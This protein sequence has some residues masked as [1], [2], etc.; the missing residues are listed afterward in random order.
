MKRTISI[1]LLVLI[2]VGLLLPGVMAAN[3]KVV[4]TY[5][6]TTYNN[7]DYKNIVDNYFST[8]SNIHEAGVKVISADEV[9]KISTSISQK[10]YNSNQIFSSA[11]VDLRNGDDL[12]VDVDTS[13][14]TTINEDMYKSALKTAGIT[15]G[16]VVV[17][18]PVS[19]TGESALAGVMGCYEE[20]TG[21]EVPENVK[22]AAN[23]EIITEKEI[24]E[25]SNVTPETL[26]E[27]V[28]EV[29]EEA[30]EKNLTNPEQIVPIINNIV[31]NNNINLTPED[32]DKLANT[33]SDIVAA[34]DDAQDLE[35]EL[36]NK[37]NN[38]QSFIDKILGFFGL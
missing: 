36:S 26:S 11:L 34:Q 1:I 23:E 32:V 15:K 21:V 8:S 3:D 14:I 4:I 38:G 31:I 37:I 29:K 19:S 5:G 25:N 12:D 20:A 35:E 28:D 27:V 22:E 17:T 33:V 2:T 24:V 13:K 6:E 30:E 9:N 7:Q 16:H 18:S 10:V